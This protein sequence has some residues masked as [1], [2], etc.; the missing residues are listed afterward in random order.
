MTH[1]S[2]N[3]ISELPEN[4]AHLAALE[5]GLAV[6]EVL[7]TTRDGLTLAEVAR[8]CGLN[9]A[10]ARRILH[11]LVSQN[12]AVTDDK[13]FMPSTRILSLGRSIVRQNGIW[14]LANKRL[15][16][17]SR[18]FNETFS[19]AILEGAEVVYV[20]R[21][22][23]ARRV[24]MADLSVGMRLP[25]WCT[26]MG[27]MMLAALPPEEIESIL[28]RSQLKSFTPH[29]IIDRDQLK[30][31]ILQAGRQGY[32]IVDQELEMGLRS[33]A[34]PLRREDGKVVAAI[35]VATSTSTASV[36]KMVADMLPAL[37]IAARDIEAAIDFM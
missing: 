24:M 13:R 5:R 35:N 21:V 16:L 3:D 1:Q 2:D 29:T 34:V 36:E 7:S 23:A 26:S 18:Q 30:A 27:R 37:R 22:L 33:L 10:T 11:T 20:A 15:Q 28:A 9:R 4:R 17:I 32:A 14:G 12:Y 31:A 6:I 8:A 19:A 25:A